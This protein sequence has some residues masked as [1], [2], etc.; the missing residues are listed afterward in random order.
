[1]ESIITKALTSTP[2]ADR[3]RRARTRI[4]RMNELMKKPTT[5]PA[6]ADRIR[7]AL[8]TIAPTHD[9]NNTAPAT[10]TGAKRTKKPTT[11][12]INR[13]AEERAERNALTADPAFTLAKKIVNAKVKSA[14]RRGATAERNVYIKH[15]DE[16]LSVALLTLQECEAEA[17]QY[18][19][20]TPAEME[21]DYFSDRY[22]HFIMACRA[23]GKEE[24]KL[25]TSTAKEGT[26]LEHISEHATTSAQEKA[27]TEREALHDWTRRALEA[28]ETNER[29]KRITAKQAANMRHLL[30]GHPEK[31]T[32]HPDDTRKHLFKLL[33]KAGL[34]MRDERG[35]LTMNHD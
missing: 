8:A 20:M 1:M 18:T 25:T 34:L 6:T 15:Y 16:F 3:I 21:T 12:P 29:T 5:H 2:T 26:P 31:V 10:A 24:Y 32:P 22:S 23:C 13:R 17:L 9:H 19:I 11:A 28:I 30:N 33:S 27:I 35:A 4:E 14:I 7:R